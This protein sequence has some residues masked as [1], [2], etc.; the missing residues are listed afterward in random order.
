MTDFYDGKRVLVTGGHGFL[1]KHLVKKLNESGAITIVPSR[2]NLDLTDGIAVT[3]FAMDGIVDY[4]DKDKRKYD[5]VF[6]LAAHVGGIQYNLEHPWT[7]IE[8]NCMMAFSAVH[9]AAAYGAKLIAAGSVCAYPKDVPVPAIEENLYEGYPEE[10]NGAYGTAKRV[11]LEAQKAAYNQFGFESVHIV[12]ANLYGPGDH[13]GPGRSHVIPSLIRKVQ[14]A[15]DTNS[16]HV[17]VWGT[18]NASRDFLYVE[19]AADAYMLAGEKISGPP[20]PINIASKDETPIHFVITK[21]CE[22][23]GF[24]GDVVY[25]KSKPDGQRRRAFRIDKMTE[26]TG[27]TPTTSIQDGLE[28]TVKWYRANVESAGIR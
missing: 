17:V 14:E 25:D 3:E 4:P 13:F 27:W 18:G 8:D 23:M 16:D 2:N 7:L 20:R 24:E 15:I 11:L 21:L 26:L 1:G 12:S 19:D 6:H 5:I 9:I 10:S 28:N 22:I